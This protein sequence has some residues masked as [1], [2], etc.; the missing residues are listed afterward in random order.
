MTSFVLRL[1]EL[2]SKWFLI[3]HVDGGRHT[4]PGKVQDSRQRVHLGGLI[5]DDGVVLG[6]GEEVS[7]DLGDGEVDRSSPIGDVWL[8]HTRAL[9]EGEVDKVDGGG[10]EEDVGRLKICVKSSQAVQLS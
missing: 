9:G 8:K 7:G 2:F 6:P 5:N 3:A 1:F 4:S 10:R